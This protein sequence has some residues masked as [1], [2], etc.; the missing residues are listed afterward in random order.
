MLSARLVGLAAFAASLSVAC[1][2]T[3]PA[4][5]AEAPPSPAM[6][7][8]W[9]VI[10]DVAFSSADIAPVARRLGGE[11]AALRNT[12]Y[13]AQGKRVQLNLIVAADEANAVAIE[14]AIHGLKPAEF[15]LRRG[16]R[17]Y[18]FVGTDEAI[19]EMRAGRAHLERDEPEG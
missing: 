14:E 4:G 19:P 2:D 3:A 12:A 13:D 7:E 10:S 8:S 5:V 17:V 11:I 18:E 6:P 15:V 9:R 16:L 1:V